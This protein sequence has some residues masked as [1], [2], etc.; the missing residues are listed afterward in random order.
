MRLKVKS[1]FRDKVTRKIYT[2]G[3][4]FETEDQAR[5][6]K[7]VDAKLA[8]VEEKKLTK[9]DICKLL[10][11]QGIEYDPKAKKEELAAILGGE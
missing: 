5:I 3:E 11:E 7:L 4:Y 2:P 9:D 8:E 10:D 1:S 6:D